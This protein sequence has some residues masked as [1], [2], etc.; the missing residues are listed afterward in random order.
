MDGNVYSLG[1]TPIIPFWRHK[2][3]VGSFTIK[4]F[5]LKEVLEEL[6]KLDFIR[7]AEIIDIPYYNVDGGIDKAIEFDYYL[8]SQKDLS[9]SLAHIIKDNPIP[10]GMKY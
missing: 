10:I 4:Y 7:N 9:K 1:E 2:H 6:N 3:Y 5:N 8:P